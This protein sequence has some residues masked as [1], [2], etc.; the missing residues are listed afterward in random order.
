MLALTA[1]GMYHA[2]GRYS[3]NSAFRY[4]AQQGSLLA[5]FT[6]TSWQEP[7]SATVPVTTLLLFLISGE[8]QSEHCHFSISQSKFDVTFCAGSEDCRRDGSGCATPLRMPWAS[9]AFSS[10]LR[11]ASPIM[12]P[13]C[14]WGSEKYPNVYV[15][16]Q[17]VFIYFA[18][19]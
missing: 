16:M 11:P 14:C 9:H 1:G 4:V 3:R 13:V 17:G 12:Y 8:R 6:D 2:H 7:A 5:C 18:E 19:T 10:S 15:E